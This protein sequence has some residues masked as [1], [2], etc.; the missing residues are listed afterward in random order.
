MGSHV[1]EWIYLLAVWQLNINKCLFLIE[2]IYWMKQ[3]GWLTSTSEDKSLLL[4]D[5]YSRD[6]IIKRKFKQWWL[7]IPPISIKRTNY[8]ASQPIEYKK[9]HNIWHCKSRSRLVKGTKMWP[10]HMAL[11]IQVQASERHKNVTTIYGIVNPGPG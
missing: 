7:T 6:N 1:S 3:T 2:I 4:K 8:L 5:H 11:Q 10:Q 9:D